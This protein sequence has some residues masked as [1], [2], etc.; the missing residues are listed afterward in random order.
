MAHLP[1]NVVALFE[2]GHIIWV[3]TATTDGIPN[4]AVKGSG[5]VSD[6][7]NLF[8]ADLFSKKTRANLEQNPNIAIGIHDGKIAVQ[9]KGRAKLSDSGPLYETVVA[10]IKVKAPALPPPTYVVEVAVES[11]FDMTGGPNA[12]NQIV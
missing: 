12:G 2:G 7:E 8:F 6:S 3:A 4:I 5:F 10:A 9:V 1:A 11:V